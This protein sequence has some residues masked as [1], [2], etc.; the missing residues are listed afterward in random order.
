M[1]SESSQ[2]LAVPNDEVLSTA[3]F[4]PALL[5][6]TVI[7]VAARI[8]FVSVAHFERIANDADF[9]RTTARNLVSGLGYAYPF[10]TDPTRSVATAAHPPLFSLLLA[11]FDLV[12][13]RSV[14]AQ[15]LGLAVASS[16]VVPLIGLVG[17]RLLSPAVGVAAA[18]IA[19]LHPLWLQTV[20]SLMSESIYLVVV[21]GLLLAALRGTG[22]PHG[23]EA[24]SSR[25]GYRNCRPCS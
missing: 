19:A 5:S 2:G 25:V 17:R 6:M 9:F 4:W 24:P 21:T 23:M 8:V 7:G 14:E 20:G 3:W 16:A 1:R 10:P 11:I 13:L 22:S 12:G 15:R 18:A